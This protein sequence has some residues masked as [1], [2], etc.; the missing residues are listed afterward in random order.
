MKYKNGTKIHI[1][2]MVEYAPAWSRIKYLV[3]ILAPLPNGRVSVRPLGGEAEIVLADQL[4]VIGRPQ[5]AGEAVTDES[6]M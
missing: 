6:E 3:E 5:G 2:E 1:G 4:E